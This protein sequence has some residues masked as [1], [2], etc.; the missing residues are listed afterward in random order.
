MKQDLKEELCEAFAA[1]SPTRKR[2][3][4]N[5]IP[6]SKIS[7]LAFLRVQITYIPQYVWGTFGI[8]LGIAILGG[9][10]LEQDILWVI[11]ALIPFIALTAVTEHVR[12]EVYLMAELEMSARFSLK[13]VLLARMMILGMVHLILMMLLIPICTIYNAVS[14]FQTGLYLLVPYVLTSAIGLWGTRK[15]Q[16]RES[17]YWCM[18][19]A[20]GISGMNL[21]IQ[22]IFPIVYEMKYSVIWL[23]VL[24]ISV[25]IIIKEAKRN[26]KQVEELAWN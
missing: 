16:G 24:I 26:L 6:Q 15:I 22:N 12:S 10:F 1:P 8:I 25:A 20:I 11:S 2:E 21:F 23:V 4:L 7:N 9:C 17:M 18:G 5:R 14:V 19:T 3:F 13:S